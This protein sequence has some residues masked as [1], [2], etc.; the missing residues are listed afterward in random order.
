MHG[1][2]EAVWGTGQSKCV[3]DVIQVEGA[4]AFMVDDTLIG[5]CPWHALANSK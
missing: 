3:V 1:E 2:C 5:A 4:A